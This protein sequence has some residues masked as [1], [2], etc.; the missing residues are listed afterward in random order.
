MLVGEPSILPLGCIEGARLYCSVELD[1]DQA[2][3]VLHNA[4]EC[5]TI[6]RQTVFDLVSTHSSRAAAS[7]EVQQHGMENCSTE[8][9]CLFN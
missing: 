8:R 1:G 7:T 6:E 2:T 3:L 5:N 4:F 9:W